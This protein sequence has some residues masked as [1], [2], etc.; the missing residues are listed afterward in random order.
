M[1]GESWMNEITLDMIPGVYQ[2]IANEIGIE[3]FFKLVNLIGGDTLYLPKEETFLKPIR[4]MKI[5]NEYNGY[6]AGFLARKYNMTTRWVQ[7]ICNN[8][9]VDGQLSMFD[10]EDD[11]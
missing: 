5:K 2:T 4:N 6:N 11:E 10:F 1:N 9:L 3:N 8:D 7:K